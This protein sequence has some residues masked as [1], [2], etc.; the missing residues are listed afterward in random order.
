MA[1]KKSRITF[2][3]ADIP[4]DIYEIL[5]DKADK[6]KLTPYIVELVETC[7]LNKLI[8]SKLE[9]IESKV[10]GISA[11]VIIRKE[12]NSELLKSQQLKEG[13]VV[14]AN[15]INGGIDDDDLEG[16]KDF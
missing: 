4:D 7:K 9:S 16:E 5:S 1:Q 6:R 2:S 10:D 8:L 11:G 14:N 13:S 12:E 15:A 3:T